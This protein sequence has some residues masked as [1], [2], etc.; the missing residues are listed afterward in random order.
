MPFESGPND[1][2][3]SIQDAV[4]TIPATELPS[5]ACRPTQAAPFKIRL[6]DD[7]KRTTAIRNTLCHPPVDKTVLTRLRE[8]RG[9]QLKY[10]GLADNIN[11]NNNSGVE[12][13]KKCLTFSA[14]GGRVE[15][16]IRV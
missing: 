12:K 1:I 3:E 15:S 10:A 2:S 11:N 16:I 14:E 8:R 4:I 5:P 13:R 6:G 9:V 7:A